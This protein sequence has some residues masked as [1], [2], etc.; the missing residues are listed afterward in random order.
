MLKLKGKFT[1][2]TR[3]VKRRPGELVSLKRTDRI[4]EVVLGGGAGYGDPA[5]RST[6]DAARDL[7]DGYVSE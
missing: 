2:L 3:R 7:A 6:E 5:D 4:V 1:C